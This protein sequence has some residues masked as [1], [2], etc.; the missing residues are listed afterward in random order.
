[1]AVQLKDGQLASLS[2]VATILDLTN[3]LE[4]DKSLLTGP[5][6]SLG[7]CVTPA[8]PLMLRVKPG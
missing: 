5:R 3:G 6:S 8:V 2:A 1:M 7:C 4:Q